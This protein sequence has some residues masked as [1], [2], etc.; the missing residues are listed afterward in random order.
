MLFNSSK[1]MMLLYLFNYVILITNVLN[2]KSYN[3][4][5][6]KN[7]KTFKHN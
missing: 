5:L 7:K 1:D 2:K 3:T 6:N 4:Q